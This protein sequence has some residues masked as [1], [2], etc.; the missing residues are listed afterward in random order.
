MDSIVEA[1]LKHTEAEES[2]EVPDAETTNFGPPRFSYVGCGDRGCGRI[3]D[4]LADRSFDLEP[5]TPL[6]DHVTTVRVGDGFE[7][8]SELGSNQ[9]DLAD[10]AMAVSGEDATLPTDLE[11]LL[12]PA[13]ICLLTLSLTDAD[14]VAGTAGL[15]SLL[16]ETPTMVFASTDGNLL[17]GA[18]RRLTEATN[19][20][21]LLDESTISEGPLSTGEEQ[22]DVLADRLVQRFVTNVVELPTVPGRVGIDYAN[23]WEQWRNGGLAVPSVARLDSQELDVETIS[24]S[25]VPL[26]HTDG[27]VEGWMGYAVAGGKLQL[28]EFDRLQKNLPQALDGSLHVQDG[29]LGGRIREE[30]GDTV[31]LS[32]LQMTG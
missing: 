19:T 16:E 6:D 17:S 22:S 28:S 14:A 3:D 5:Q 21:V 15:V 32:A 20:T 30:L 27:A 2:E 12:A 31:V 10:T 8:D 25:L 29:V 1:A 26:A 4:G 24:E 13:D 23:V 11:G 18:L 9:F 7:V